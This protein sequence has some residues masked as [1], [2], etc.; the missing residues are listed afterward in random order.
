MANRTGKGTFTKGDAR[1]NR[2]GRPRDFDALRALAQQVAH[3]PARTA[4]GQPLVV[5][6]KPVTLTEAIL[7][8]WAVSHDTRLQMAFIEITYG[9]VPAPIEVSGLGGGPVEIRVV[10]DDDNPDSSPS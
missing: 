9:K 1:I 2:K 10:Y 7:R 6:G 8:K 3:E 4:D 5:N